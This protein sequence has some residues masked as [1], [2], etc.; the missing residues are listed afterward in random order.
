[1]P[2]RQSSGIF[3][4]IQTQ[5]RSL[6]LLEATVACTRLQPLI[7]SSTIIL[8]IPAALSFSVTYDVSNFIECDRTFGYMDKSVGAFAAAADVSWLCG[9]G[10]LFNSSLECSFH[11]YLAVTIIIV[12][13]YVACF[14]FDNVYVVFH[15][16]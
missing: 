16:G 9:T 7:K 11:L 5:T 8:H 2:L 4:L 10:S 1:M 13:D 3:S 12:A 15:C 6:L 14:V